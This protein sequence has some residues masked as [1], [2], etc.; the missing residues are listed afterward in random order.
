MSCP[1]GRQATSLGQA[2]CTECLQGAVCDARDATLV[3]APGFHYEYGLLLP[4]DVEGRCLGGEP[5]EALV[6]RGSL[7]G[8]GL[9][10]AKEMPR[11]WVLLSH[12]Y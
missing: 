8:V 2:R 12:Y 11:A 10:C 6:V 4:C 1:I 3:V 7:Q 9:D 5:S